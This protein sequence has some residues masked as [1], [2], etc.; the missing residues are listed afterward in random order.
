[1]AQARLTPTGWSLIQHAVGYAWPG[2]HQDKLRASAQAWGTAANA[3]DE[4]G[5]QIPGA[6]AELILN[7]SPEIGTA[8]VV[9]RSMGEHLTSLSAAYRV[10]QN[11]CDHYAEYLDRAHRDAEHELN[12]LIEWTVGIE[13]MGVLASLVTF[14]GAEVPTQAVEAG[15]IAVTAARIADIIRTFIAAV[16][17]VT[18]AVASVVA[19]AVDISRGLKGLLGARLSK[20]TAE[21]VS[22]LPGG[23]KTAEE[24]AEKELAGELNRA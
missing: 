16:N 21:L 20:A 2:G 5:W 3:V 4:A 10:L 18:E 11:A 23:T 14:G 19:K 17:L 1:M 15:R 24:I 13:A 22:R 7:E 12:S 6:T 8:Y 9:S